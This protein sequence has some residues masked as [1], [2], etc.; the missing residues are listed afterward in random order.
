[1]TRGSEHSRL[2]EPIQRITTDDSCAATKEH[3]SLLRLGQ[4]AQKVDPATGETF[5]ML[6]HSIE[7]DIGQM[8]FQAP[9]VF[10]YYLPDYQP[11]G[12]LIG[13]TPSRRIPREGLF[14]PEFQVLNAVTANRTMN[15]LVGYARNRFVPHGTRGGTCRIYFDLDEE[16]QLAKDNANLPEIL[17]RFD[18]W[19]CNGTL[20]EDT[21]TSIINAIT[22]ESSASNQNTQRL[23]EALLAVLLSPDCAIEE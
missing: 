14:A 23:E 12:D 22:S 15:R 13:Y 6:N 1:M 5:M 20:S 16:L 19:L 7:Q 17:R 2:R 21:K 8:P 3:L 4:P 10:N 11:P 18:L 9:S